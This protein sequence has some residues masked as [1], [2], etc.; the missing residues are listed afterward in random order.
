MTETCIITPMASQIK[1]GAECSVDYN[2]KQNTE[3]G[4]T[5]NNVWQTIM[6]STVL[7][8][9]ERDGLKSDHVDNNSKLNVD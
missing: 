9:T 5:K 8:A 7:W 1:Q 3:I 2:N 6:A 4:Q